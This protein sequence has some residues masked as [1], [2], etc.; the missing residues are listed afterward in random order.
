MYLEEFI[1]Y[2]GKEKRYSP[3]T[4][5]SYRKDISQFWDY[6]T[7]TFEAE[8]ASEVSHF[9]V[10][11]WMVSLMEQGVSNR[12]VNRKLSALKTYFKYL[13][14]HNHVAK[15]PM[16]KVEPPKV[17]KRLPVFVE[18]KHMNRLLDEVVFPDDFSG[19]RDKMIIDLLYN[20]G[21]RKAG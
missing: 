2:L 4:L 12:S 5:T 1:S 13:M 15:N 6:I 21:M 7:E 11:S 20:T 9:Y 10:R 18:Q 19:A 3:H 14:R 16:L 17:S 8:N